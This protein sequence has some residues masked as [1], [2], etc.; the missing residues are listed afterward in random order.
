MR[1]G[2]QVVLLLVSAALLAGA[3][4]TS[5]R[6]EQL[7]RD[8]QQQRQLNA[9]QAQELERVRNTI[10]NLTV[11]QKATLT[12]LDGL[13]RN[14]TQLV[15][16]VATLAAR[17][18]LAEQL[19]ADT[20]AAKG[21]TETRVSRLQE[22]VR[23]ILNTLYR[24][25]SGRYL[26]LL[27]QSRSLSDLLIRLNYNNISGKYNVKVIETLRS[28]V[29][30]L[31]QQE[32]QQAQ[33]T[34]A[35]KDLQTQRAEV[36]ANLKERRQ[37]QQ[38]LLAT[39][40]KSEQ[41]QRTIAAQTQAEQ[42]LTGRTIDNLVGAVVQERARI[43]AE[44]QRRLEEERQR[45]L[46]ELRRIREAQERA[47]REAARLEAVRVAQERAARIEAARLEAARREAARIQVAREQQQR[48]QAERERLVRQQEA[49]ALAQRNA[50]AAQSARRT[51]VQQEQQRLAQQQ[52]QAEAAQ[53]EVEQ[54]I[55]PLPP[56]SGPTGFPL[57]GGQ[58]SQDY[59]ANGAQWVV[60]SAPG[61]TQAAAT[62]AGNVIAA[63]YYNSLGWVILV[64]HGS[65]VSAYFGLQDP[66]VSVGNRVAQGTPLGAIGGS[67]I[68][69][70][71][72]MAFQLNRVDGGTRQPVN[73]GF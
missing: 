55:A 36:L 65:T 39:L 18:R 28:E 40:R 73:P 49:R 58:V 3:Q 2:R 57:P 37:E 14:V 44:R 54:Q 66:Q 9:A 64:D 20:T 67:P 70:P 60:L 41:G 24:E 38:T 26:Q 15:N 13:G 62:A 19:L 7:Q 56:S 11:Q 5:E 52:Q 22:D 63:T 72:R 42:V 21:R 23:Q 27:S 25:R 17:T 50:E 43:E 46:A 59:G 8:L 33:Q 53:V 10:Q 51:A 47:R 71:D 16:E 6:L 48:A 35:L 29:A 31:K 30:S 32:A 45:R 1:A 61:G 69:G 4:T 68:F 12:R 34:A